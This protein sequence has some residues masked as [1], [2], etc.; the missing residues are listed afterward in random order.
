MQEPKIISP[1]LVGVNS[2]GTPF[3]KD[4]EGEYNYVIYKR[5]NKGNYEYHTD[6]NDNIYTFADEQEAQMF[7]N[8]LNH[9]YLTVRNVLWLINH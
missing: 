1:Y 3:Y 8:Q 6:K 9:Q 5:D 2:Y 7:C 4:E